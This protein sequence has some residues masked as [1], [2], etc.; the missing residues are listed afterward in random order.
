MPRFATTVAVLLAGLAACAAPRYPLDEDELR[1]FLNAGPVELELDREEL[2]RGLPSP[3]R[4]RLV[5]GDL[6]EVTGPWGL[7][8]TPADDAQAAGEL[9]RAVRVDDEGFVHV[10][11]AGRVKARGKTVLDVERAIVEAVYPSVLVR[12]PSVVVRVQEH[13]TLPVNVVG[14]VEQPGVHELRSNQLSLYG[15]LAAAGGILKPNNLIVGARRIRVRRA[16]GAGVEDVV[17]PVRG[18]NIPFADVGLYGGETI[19]VERY[20]PDTFTIVGLVQNPGAYPYPPETDYNLMQALAFAGGV[21]LIADPPFAT[22]FRRD[23]DGTILPATFSIAGDGLVAA[24]ALQIK[25]GDVIAVEH[26]AASWT[27]SLIAQIVRVQFGFF[28]DDR[29][30]N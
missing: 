21:D 28:V 8:A 25:P 1:R 3:G 27:R 15:A 4:Y 7:F 24:S 18:L 17:L 23:A 16:D 22:V 12:R 29:V 10:G 5:A 26:T 14:A 30:R 19:E 6:L 20:E 2:A 11:A 13:H 9:S